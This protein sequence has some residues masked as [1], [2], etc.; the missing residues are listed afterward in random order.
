MLDWRVDTFLDVCETLNYTHTARRLNITQPAV[1]QHISWMEK[2]LGVTLFVRQGRSLV[3]TEAAELVRDLLLS[4]RNDEDHLKKELLSLESK[5]MS[6]V[7]GAT[8]TAGE[9]MLAAPLAAWCSQHPLV[10]VRIDIADTADLLGKLDKGSIDCALVEGI[11]DSTKYSCREW[12]Y[13]RMVCVEGAQG[14]GSYS[15]AVGF[16]DLLEKTLVIRE[17]GSGSRAVLEA[18]LARNNL[19]PGSFNRVIEANGIGLVLE[20]VSKGLGITFAYESAVKAR[21]ARSELREIPLYEEGLGHSINFVWQRNG[22]F[23]DR[24]DQLFVDL[25]ALA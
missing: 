19:V 2:Q 16:A 3:L 15:E 21:I 22:F 24:F 4:Q 1:S 20:M 5:K 7:V 10:D 6:L 23:S 25:K 14:K 8:L 12:S 9:F 11:F 13:E 18:A 17:A